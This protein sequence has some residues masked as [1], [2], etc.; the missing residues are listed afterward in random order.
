[1]TESFIWKHLST[2]EDLK[3]LSNINKYFQLSIALIVISLGLRVFFDFNCRKRKSIAF[4]HGNNDRI[5][6]FIF[7]NDYNTYY[8]LL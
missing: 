4:I 6:D 1:M 8:H 3:H 5:I 2:T 7:K